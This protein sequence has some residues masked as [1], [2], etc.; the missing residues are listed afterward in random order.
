MS[1]ACDASTRDLDSKVPRR[2]LHDCCRARRKRSRSLDTAFARFVLRLKCLLAL[3][4]DFLAL[5]VHVVLPMQGDTLSNRGLGP[6]VACGT[7]ESR[8]SDA[9]LMNRSIRALNSR[10]DAVSAWFPSIFARVPAKH[11]AK[12]DDP[13]PLA[14][15]I[16][17]APARRVHRTTHLS[18][19]SGPDN[20]HGLRNATAVRARPEL[21]ANA[22]STYPTPG[23]MM[24]PPTTWCEKRASAADESAPENTTASSSRDCCGPGASIIQLNRVV[25]LGLT[26][27]RL[28]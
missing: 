27:R 25:S 26:N 14:L 19:R 13:V 16:S 6:K 23:N 28:R 11:E 15:A 4:G 24:V 1:H 18:A 9:A 2:D 3:H 17:S 7:T 21:A 12:L 8:R 22:I 20:K 5:N 10:P